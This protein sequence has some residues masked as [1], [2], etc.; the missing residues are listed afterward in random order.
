MNKRIIPLIVLSIF[1]SKSL[2][3]ETPKH[4]VTFGSQGLGG[5]FY[6]EQMKTGDS[7]DFKR[8]DR[9][10]TNLGFNYAYRLTQRIQIGGFY[11]TSQEEYDFNPRESGRATSKIDSTSIGIFALYNFHDEIDNAFY[12]G[13]SAANFNYEEQNSQSFVSAENKTP[14]EIDD[15][16][17]S[18]ELFFGKRF[19]LISR[20]IRHLTYA[21]Q[22]GVFMKTH[23]KDFNDQNIGQGSGVS[24]HALKFD[25]L[26]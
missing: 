4:M 16:G 19:D 22:V 3:A 21:P 6:T 8:V 25:F 20:S 10:F 14:Y 23:S 12:V 13:V 9:L 15:A 1:F 18:Y 17:Q 26:F 7:S 5:S 2:F 11:S 24:I